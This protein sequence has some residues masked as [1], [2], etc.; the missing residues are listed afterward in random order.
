MLARPAGND[1]LFHTAVGA[2]DNAPILGIRVKR[3]SNSGALTAGPN[4]EYPEKY[5][6][7]NARGEVTGQP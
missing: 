6:C 5:F 2:S 7:L 1:V 3:A 4:G